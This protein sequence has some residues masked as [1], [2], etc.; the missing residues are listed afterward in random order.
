MVTGFFGFWGGVFEGKC[1]TQDKRTN[2]GRLPTKQKELELYIESIIRLEEPKTFEEFIQHLKNYGC[3]VK[4]KTSSGKSRKHISIKMPGHERAKRLDS[5]SEEYS[6]ERLR[7]RFEV[8]KDFSFD[9][10]STINFD[11]DLQPVSEKSG[12]KLDEHEEWDETAHSESE[13]QFAVEDKEFERTLKE[14]R[15]RS[16]PRAR[17]GS[18]RKADANTEGRSSESGKGA[19]Q[20]CFHARE[21]AKSNAQ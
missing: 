9:A 18:G 21:L 5:L 7:E 10:L 1:Q 15:V 20:S 2:E 3:E 14:A 6:E 17:H 16:D 19:R 11:E 8:F 4:D 12:Y 13:K